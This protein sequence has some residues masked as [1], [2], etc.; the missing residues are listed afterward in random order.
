[1]ASTPTIWIGWLTAISSEYCKLWKHS[2]TEADFC[3]CSYTLAPRMAS[4]Y[5]AYSLLIGYSSYLDGGYSNHM[6]VAHSYCYMYKFLTS[7]SL[8]LSVSL[9]QG[10]ELKENNVSGNLCLRSPWPAMARTIYG[11]HQK[12]L[13]TYF[14]RYPGWG[15]PSHTLDSSLN[16]LSQSGSSLTNIHIH[17]I[18]LLTVS[19]LKSNIL[20]KHKKT[21]HTVFPI[22]DSIVHAHHTNVYEVSLL[23]LWNPLLKFNIYST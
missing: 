6:G 12:F 1:M 3:W 13:D 8:S 2:S 14:S 20:W 16:H 21:C 10:N 15:R 19:K 7:P 11:N 23:N 17:I 18:I 9:T 4:S 5:Y 22:H